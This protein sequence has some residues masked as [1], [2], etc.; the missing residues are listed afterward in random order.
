MHGAA[1]EGKEGAVVL[2]I[3]VLLRQLFKPSPLAA[4]EPWGGR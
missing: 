2:V 4:V 1:F 3:L